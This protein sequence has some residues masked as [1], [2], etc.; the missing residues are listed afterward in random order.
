MTLQA[1]SLGKDEHAD[2]VVLTTW[3]QRAAKALVTIWHCLGKGAFPAQLTPHY[4]LRDIYFVEGQDDGE[5]RLA[6]A[7]T[8]AASCLAAGAFLGGAV[9]PCVLP[10]CAPPW[11]PPWPP[12]G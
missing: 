5:A 12:S 8:L 7:W 9:W 2:V 10:S 1:N 11:P 6:L 3:A 4:A